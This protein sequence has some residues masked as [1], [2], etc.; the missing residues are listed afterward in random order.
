MSF[1]WR[2]ISFISLMAVH[3][4]QC[5]VVWE[6]FSS[7]NSSHWKAYSTS[8]T[9]I[10]EK[11]Y[12]NKLTQVLLGD[13]DPSLG[14]FRLDI[15]MNNGLLNCYNVIFNFLGLVWHPW[16]KYVKL[17]KKQAQWEEC[18]IPGVVQ[19]DKE[20]DG[21]GLVIGFLSGMSTVWKL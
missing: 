10:L 6:F 11:A 18:S 8:V 4:Q 13:A 21:I 14:R 15:W 16:L 19:L 9:Q 1:C 17:E 5:V 12:Q 20:S 2:L 3:V 7:P